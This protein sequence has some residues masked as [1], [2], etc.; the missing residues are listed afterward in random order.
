MYLD[1]IVFLLKLAGK[2]IPNW[3]NYYEQKE[4]G[5][6]AVKLIIQCKINI[7]SSMS[8]NSSKTLL[9]PCNC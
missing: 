4:K 1:L 9:G 5:H 3:G 7:L 2:D 6:A 8:Y